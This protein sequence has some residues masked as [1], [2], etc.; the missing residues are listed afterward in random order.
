MYENFYTTFGIKSKLLILAGNDGYVWVTTLP[1]FSYV[2]EASAEITSKVRRDLTGN[3]TEKLKKRQEKKM[4]ANLNFLNNSSKFRRLFLP[5]IDEV[6][7]VV[8]IL[9]VGRVQFEEWCV[10]LHQVSYPSL[11]LPAKV[12]HKQHELTVLITNI[13]SMPKHSTLNLCC[14]PLDIVQ[15]NE[16]SWS[17]YNL[18]MW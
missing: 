16:S 7:S 4:H 5:G 17:H 9:H 2:S 13:K 6:H 15:Y 11:V 12:T 1:F 8:K 10:L 3:K 18:T 14:T